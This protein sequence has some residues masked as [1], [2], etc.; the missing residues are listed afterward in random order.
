MHTILTDNGA[1]FTDELLAEH[2][3]PKN[4]THVFDETFENAEIRHKLTK[5]RHPWTNAH[6]GVF[7]R[8]IKDHTTKKYD[9]DA[10]ES[11]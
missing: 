1:Q 11:L 2:L 8:K 4:K 9:Y 3:R 6:L 5:S 10:L 7:N